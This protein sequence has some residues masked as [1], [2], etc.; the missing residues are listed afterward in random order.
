MS[1]TRTTVSNCARILFRWNIKH[2]LRNCLIR[3]K[4]TSKFKGRLK[5]DRNSFKILLAGPVQTVVVANIP[6]LTENSQNRQKFQILRNPSKWFKKNY[7]QRG[8]NGQIWTL[9]NWSN[10]SFSRISPL[11]QLNKEKLTIS[12]P[13]LQG[14]PRTKQSKTILRSLRS[15]NQPSTAPTQQPTNK[16]TNLTSNRQL[17]P[18]NQ[19]QERSVPNQTPIL[20]SL[21]LIDSSQSCNSVAVIAN[22]PH[23]PKSE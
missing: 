15:R 11:T 20:T 19:L 16:P 22:W 13:R 14:T 18:Q 8:K 4:I 12:S 21:T 9:K 10:F 2:R 7:L 17:C 1:G 3:N 6:H 5:L 23:H